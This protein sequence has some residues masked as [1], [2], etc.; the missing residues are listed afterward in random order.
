M[1]KKIIDSLNI[2][3]TNDIKTNFQIK[4][5]GL[6]FGSFDPFHLGHKEILDLG[7]DRSD[8]M[9]IGLSEKNNRQRPSI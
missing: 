2:L 6:Y 4:T 7:I 1:N 9:V 8:I 5:I 3:Y